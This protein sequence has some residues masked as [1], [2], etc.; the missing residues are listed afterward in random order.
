MLSVVRSHWEIGSKVL[1]DMFIPGASI[2]ETDA[3]AK[4]QRESATPEVAAGYLELVYSADVTEAARLIKA[5]TIVLHR[6][7]DRAIPIAGG[8]QLAAFVPG[9]HFVPLEG[10]AHTPRDAEEAEELVALIDDHLLADGALSPTAT[11]SSATSAASEVQVI[12]FTDL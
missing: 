12:L 10:R 2:E 4:N 8:H 6:Q 1:T 11:A 3:F 9:A 5:P 7:G